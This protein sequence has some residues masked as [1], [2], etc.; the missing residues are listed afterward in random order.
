MYYFL[1]HVTVIFCV[2][3][4]LNWIFF[5]KCGK[6]Q[7]VC[8]NQRTVLYKGTPEKSAIQK[9][10]I[11][12]IYVKLQIRQN[13]A[14]RLWPLTSQWSFTRENL[15]FGGQVPDSEARTGFIQKNYFKIHKLFTNLCDMAWKSNLKVCNSSTPLVKGH[16]PYCSRWPMH[17]ISQNW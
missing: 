10:S 6:A 3:F 7:W 14:F 12:I 15:C 16:N 1:E 11:I 2:S 17:S 5:L 13:S 9:L 4:S 8:V